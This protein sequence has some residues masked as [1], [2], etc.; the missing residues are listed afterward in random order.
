[1]LMHGALLSLKGLKTRHASTKRLRAENFIPAWIPAAYSEKKVSLC[2]SALSEQSKTCDAGIYNE[3]WAPRK[4]RK[5]CR[6]CTSDHG[7]VGDE[8]PSVVLGIAARQRTSR[9]AGGSLLTG[10]SSRSHW[11]YRCQPHNH[12][13]HPVR[14]RGRSHDQRETRRRPKL[15]NLPRVCPESAHRR[16]RP[17]T[18]GHDSYV[19]FVKPTARP[20][21]S[22]LRIFPLPA[23]QNLG[24]R[25]HKRS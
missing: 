25:A 17:P 19:L 6:R 9:A 15:P 12:T 23:D 5:K 16:A 14:R 24:C 1:M 3:S 20:V 18:A 10:L 21:Y 2:L 11:R 8:N 22:W 7:R 4:L 13:L